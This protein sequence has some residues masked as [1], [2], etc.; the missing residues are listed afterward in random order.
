MYH[1]PEKKRLSSEYEEP[2]ILVESDSNFADLTLD[3]EA[4]M[5]DF[6]PETA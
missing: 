4:E 3:K 1:M 2:F 6:T 5:N